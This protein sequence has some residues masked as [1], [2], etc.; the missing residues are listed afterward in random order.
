MRP[1]W[2]VKGSSGDGVGM[3]EGIRK[4]RGEDMD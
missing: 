2:S 1:P 4:V 3:A